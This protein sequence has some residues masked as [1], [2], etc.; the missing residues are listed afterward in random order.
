MSATVIRDAIE[1]TSRFI[2]EQ[3]EK[4]RS[5]TAPATRGNVVEI[6]AVVK[7]SH[8]AHEVLV[9]TGSMAQSLAV[10]AKPAGKGSA[11]PVELVA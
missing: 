9:R 4:A 7:S 3:P 8:P 6:S 11:V 10:A 5:K 1:K 2:A